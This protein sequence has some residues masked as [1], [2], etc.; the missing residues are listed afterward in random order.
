LALIGN[1][2][3]SNALISQHPKP[4][5]VR[6]VLGLEAKNPA[7]IFDDADIDLAVKECVKG[8]WSFNGQ[9]CTALKVIYVH[10]RIRKE[11]LDAFSKATDALVSGSPFEN[12]DITPL[13]EQGKVKYMQS[14]VDEAV[15]K[16]ARV[17]NERGGEVEGNVFFPAILFPTHRDTA[18]FR[19]E[20]FGPVCPVLEFDDFE[21]VLTDVAE[22][23]YGQQVSI[24]TRDAQAAG[25]CIDHLVNQVCRVNIN[26]SCQR[27]P[28]A[29]PFTGRKDSAVSTL[30]V[31]AALRSF[32][33]RTLV[34][35]SEDQK[36]LM[37]EV[38]AGG[39][40]SFSS[41]NYLL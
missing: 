11:F 34:A 22:S 39:H 13:P 8:A 25:K 23:N 31:K 6:Q 3:S 20:Q 40:S 41:M 17:V 24:F 37:E 28:D 7:I 21:E 15:S 4:N 18:I 14:Y 1:S 30:S 33:I 35:C 12:A 16:G 2:K 5:R 32:S 36:G 9:R 27:G 19:E 29:L 26:A 10:K 38:I